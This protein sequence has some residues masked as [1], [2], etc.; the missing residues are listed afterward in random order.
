MTVHPDL[1]LGK[2][3]DALQDV[4]YADIILSDP[5]Y[6]SRTHDGERGGMRVRVVDERYAARGDG[7]Q[8]RNG[9]RYGPI[10][11]SD[12]VAFVASWAPRVR[13]WAIL[14]GDHTTFRLWEAAWMAAGWVTFA[15]VLWI[16]LD[17]AP[18][19]SGDG[20]ASSAEYLCVAR[21]R[22]R[23]TNHASRAGHYLVH[24]PHRSQDSNGSTAVIG[25][26][27][28]AGLRAILTDYTRPGDLVVDPY[29]G[30]ATVGQACVELGR[31]YIGAEC[32]PVTHAKGVARLAKAVADPVL[33]DRWAMELRQIALDFGTTEGTR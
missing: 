8:P 9:I 15:P 3:Q 23:V 12:I 28:N 16:K 18:R 1:R 11:E 30:T 17:A 4:E 29:S 32:D 26:K 27:S 33:A 5:P 6:S 10:A 7:R 21:P 14:F 22:R 20:P 2:W 19:F 24:S 13:A 25:T 31:R